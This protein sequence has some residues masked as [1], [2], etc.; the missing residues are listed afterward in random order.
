MSS[1]SMLRRKR[2]NQNMSHDHELM[3]MVRLNKTEQS[4]IE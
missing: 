2:T 4:W 1:R 3:L